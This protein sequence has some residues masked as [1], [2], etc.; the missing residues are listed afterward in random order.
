MKRIFN[1]PPM[2]EKPTMWR[3]LAELENSPGFA[4]IVDR[5]FPRGAGVLSLIHI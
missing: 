3:S 1:H 5:E 2:P 4:E